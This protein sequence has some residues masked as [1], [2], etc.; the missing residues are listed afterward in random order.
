VPDPYSDL[1]FSRVP[2][3]FPGSADGYRYCKELRALCVADV[4]AEI[5]RSGLKAVGYSDIPRKTA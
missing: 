2:D 3:R 1:S 4:L 5:R